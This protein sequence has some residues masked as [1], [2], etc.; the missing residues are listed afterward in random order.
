VEVARFPLRVHTRLILYPILREIQT[1][2]C[3]S[4][5]LVSTRGKKRRDEV[6]SILF[7]FIVGTQHGIIHSSKEQDSVPFSLLSLYSSGH[8]LRRCTSESELT[9]P[10]PAGVASAAVADRGV[11]GVVLL[12][13]CVNMTGGPD[14]RTSPCNHTNTHACTHPFTLTHGGDAVDRPVHFLRVTSEY[15]SE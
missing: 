3:V 14:E 7:F 11:D 2:W 9:L 10:P 1:H 4:G 15:V 6:C 12:S 8:E 5:S 13:P